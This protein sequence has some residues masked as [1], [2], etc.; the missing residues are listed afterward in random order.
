MNYILSICLFL[1]PKTFVHKNTYACGSLRDK[2][3][4]YIKREKTEIC[5]FEVKTMSILATH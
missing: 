4:I 1:Q 5:L 3:V 2:F